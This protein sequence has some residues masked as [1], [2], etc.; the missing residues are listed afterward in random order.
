MDVAVTRELNMLC[1]QNTLE[2]PVAGHIKLFCRLYNLQWLERLKVR[3]TSQRSAEYS[4][5]IGCTI[6]A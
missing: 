5:Q 3:P 2:V 4:S 1:I 6:T